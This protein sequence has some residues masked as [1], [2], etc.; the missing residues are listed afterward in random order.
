M[1]HSSTLPTPCPWSCH[2]AP[3]SITWPSLGGKSYFPAHI[4]TQCSMLP[5]PH[6]LLASPWNSRE[7]GTPVQGGPSAPIAGT[8]N[9]LGFS[10]ELRSLKPMLGILA[11]ELPQLAGLVLLSWQQSHWTA[12]PEAWAENQAQDLPLLADLV[13]LSWVSS[14]ATKLSSWKPVW[15]IRPQDFHYLKAWF[16][17]ACSATALPSWSPHLESRP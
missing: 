5:Q 13:L 7:T 12:L 2:T 8:A 4:G 16:P 11:Q 3:S 15:E 10:T 9:S 6:D 1:T 14:R 17:H